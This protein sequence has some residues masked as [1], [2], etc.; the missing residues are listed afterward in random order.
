MKI[1]KK[2]LYY[3]FGVLLGL[4][5]VN[6]FWDQKDIKMTY[7]PS[8]RIQ[9]DFGKKPLEFKPEAVKQLNDYSISKVTIRE[10]IEEGAFDAKLLDRDAK[11]CK[12]YSLKSDFNNKPFDLWFQNCD[13]TVILYQVNVE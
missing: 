3:G 1:G 8:S 2:L 11:P 9:H 10:K 7:F 12:T 5:A 13:S 4:L 6:F